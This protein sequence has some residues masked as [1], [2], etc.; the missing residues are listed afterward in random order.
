MKKI[1]PFIMVIF[2]ISCSLF[3][4]EKDAYK[5]KDWFPLYEAGDTVKY[6]VIDSVTTFYEDTIVGLVKNYDEDDYQ[7]TDIVLSAEKQLVSI[8]R[9]NPDTVMTYYII[10]DDI[11]GSIIQSSD[12]TKSADDM[13]LLDVPVM[14]S[15]AWDCNGY[16]GESIHY[17]IESIDTILHL[18]GISFSNVLYITGTGTGTDEDDWEKLWFSPEYGVLKWEAQNHTYETRENGY[19]RIHK[20]Y[21][22]IME[23]GK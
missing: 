8:E 7:L 18:D 14:L 9:H 12:S 13:I 19:V 3:N 4:N 22:L 16:Y 6:D 5:I 21:H 11:N 20:W 1:F 15:A 17:V 10:R 23:K 2:L